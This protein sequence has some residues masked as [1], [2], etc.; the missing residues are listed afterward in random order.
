ML[1]LLYMLPVYTVS[2]ISSTLRSIQNQATSLHLHCVALDTASTSIFA[3]SLFLPFY[4]LQSSLS[5]AA[6]SIFQKSLLCSK[7]CQH[8]AKA[9]SFPGST[10]PG[11]QGPTSTSLPLPHSR[12]S[13]WYCA[14]T[15]PST[16]YLRTFPL[17]ALCFSSSLQRAS[18]HALR[19]STEM[20]HHLH[21][22][23]PDP[24]TVEGNP[25]SV[26]LAW[27]TPPA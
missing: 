25:F 2:P 11:W 4:Q 20:S 27:P 14:M 22:A 3:I 13:H 26:D 1:I 6:S 17:T 18:I 23:L 21:M 8:G 12:F 15:M 7:P 16:S 19:V 9:K 5:R 10:R 24:T